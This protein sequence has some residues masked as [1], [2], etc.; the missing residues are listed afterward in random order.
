MRNYDEFY[1]EAYGDEFIPKEG[2]I[3]PPTAARYLRNCGAYL[4]ELRQESPLYDVLQSSPRRCSR[5]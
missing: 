1:D 3:S 5:Q 2:G 4:R